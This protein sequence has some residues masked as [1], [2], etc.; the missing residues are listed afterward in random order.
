MHLLQ[1]TSSSSFWKVIQPL[2]EWLLVKINNDWG[3]SYFDTIF[4]FIRETLFWFPLYLF[5]FLW[6]IMQFGAKGWWWIAGLLL[7][8]AFCDII[9]S[10]V[11]KVLIFRTR[12]CQDAEVG[13]LIHFFINYCPKSSSFT[14]SHATTHFG[15]AMFYFITLRNMGKWWMLGF[16]WAFAIVYTQVY[17][18]VHYPF[19]VLCGALIG[20]IIGWITGKLF[21]KQTGMLSLDK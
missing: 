12:P 21:L 5:V 8:A 14:S 19:D 9:S 1:S 16:G 17:V 4:P 10:Q 13:N 20:C 15:Q 18:G 2:D 3:N 6:I 11:I 7:T